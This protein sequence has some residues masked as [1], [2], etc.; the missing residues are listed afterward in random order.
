MLGSYTMVRNGLR[1]KPRF[2]LIPGVTYW[3]VFDTKLGLPH[4]SWLY[5]I[6]KS[7]TVPRP[8]TIP[9]RVAAVYPSTDRLPENQLK[10]YLHFSAPM[11][12]GEAYEHIHLFHSSGREV[13]YP[14]LKLG[15]ELW[16]P[17]GTRFTL[18][19]DPG[20]I[21]RGLKPREEVGPVLEAGNG[22]TLVIDADWL[23]AAG[24]PLVETHR[25]SFQVGSPDEQVLD[26]KAWRLDPPRAATKAPLVLR[27][28]EP[29]DHAM[30]GR[31]L[32]VTDAAGNAVAGR[33]TVSRQETHWQFTPERPWAAGDYTI[34]I[35]TTLEDLA[36]NSIG[37]PFEVDVVR[38]IE[39]RIEARTVSIPFPVAAS[40]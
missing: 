1:F 3:A 19:I 34:V 23:D 37:Q 6:G 32:V 20:R 33:I 9:T 5:G 24:N 11:S 28:P 10:F 22:Y 18:F 38:V 7:F 4:H 35:D 25:K 13:D 17:A 21:K 26:V 30:L 8:A 2:P 40:R 16:N 14:F 39:R 36:G 29:L 27:F 15:E 12:Q 31:V